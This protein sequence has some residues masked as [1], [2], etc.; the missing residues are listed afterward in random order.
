MKVFRV[1]TRR[2]PLAQAQTQLVVR[3]IKEAYPDLA[4]ETVTFETTGDRAQG[5]LATVG[6]KGLFTLELEHALRCGDVDIAVHS[7]KDLPAEIDSAFAI[8]AAMPRGDVRDTL[9]TK[10]ATGLEALPI[11]ANVG[12]G[13]LRRKVQLQVLRPDLQLI[14]IRGNVQTRVSKVTDGELDAVVLAQAGLIRSG[15]A[16]LHPDL[17]HPFSPE[18][19]LPAGGQGILAI[20][21]RVDDIETR[22]LLDRINNPV[23]LRSLETERVIVRAVGADCHSCLAVY[24]SESNVGWTVRALASDVSGKTVLRVE[25]SDEDACRASIMVAEAL[26]DQGARQLLSG[27]GSP[28]EK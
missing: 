24:A 13:S 5:E 7:A 8:A 18:Q 22:Q 15:L 10:H 12:T 11:G 28:G 27:D 20:E 6:G 9:V 17:L 3:A 2:S 14:P 4:V 19:M 1:A 26:L 16:D 25:I 21:T 23:S